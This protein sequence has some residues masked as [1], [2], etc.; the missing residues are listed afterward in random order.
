MNGGMCVRRVRFRVVGFTL[1][2]LLV[3][4]VII[5]LLL[6]VLLPSLKKAKDLAKRAVCLAHLHSLGISWILYADEDDGRI[7]NAKT[8]RIDEISANPRQFNWRA[9]NNY[10]TGPTWVG[11]F[12]EP[13]DTYGDFIVDEIARQ[14]CIKL[15]SM[16]PYNET[17]DIY[18]CPVGIRNELRTYAITDAMNGHDGFEPVGGK[19]IRKLNEL[20]SPGTRLVFIDEGWASTESWTINPDIVQWWDGV[21]LRHGDGTTVTMADGSAEY[22]KWKDQKTIDFANGIGDNI[23]TAINNVDFDKIQRAAWGKAAR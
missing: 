4:I 20:P 13:T 11:W 14:A 19:V 9:F 8:A 18:R 15:G 21:P 7:P 2:E 10:H 6:A 3:V 17:L 22:W 23:S 12:D 16:F 1:I 5:A